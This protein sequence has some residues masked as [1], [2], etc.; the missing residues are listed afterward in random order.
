MKTTTAAMQLMARSL[1]DQAEMQG[2]QGPRGPP[3]LQPALKE[4]RN[5]RRAGR[6]LS[7]GKHQFPSHSK[8]KEVQVEINAI[9]FLSQIFS[10]M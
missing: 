2:A 6:K 9:E 3:S 7:E 4:D 5:E 8:K 1:L 10:K